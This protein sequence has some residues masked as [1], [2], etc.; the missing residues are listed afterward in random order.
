MV[1]KCLTGSVMTLTVGWTEQPLTVDTNDLAAPSLINQSGP[2][3]VKELLKT[4]CCMRQPVAT[5]TAVPHTHM[6]SHLAPLCCGH[7]AVTLLLRPTL[8]LP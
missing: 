1:G 2:A 8:P 5:L 3:Q 7:T 4:E 6:T